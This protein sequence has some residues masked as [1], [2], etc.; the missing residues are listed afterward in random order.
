M[1]IEFKMDDKERVELN[2]NLDNITI[3][4]SDE[5]LAFYF[6]N[7]EE[8]ASVDCTKVQCVIVSMCGNPELVEM[9]QF[10]PQQ[11]AHEVINKIEVWRVMFDDEKLKRN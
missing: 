2:F 3:S 1:N 7:G 9:H 8:L 6:N 11:I 4:R 5:K 10:T